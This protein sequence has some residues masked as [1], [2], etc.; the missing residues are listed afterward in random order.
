[1]TQLSQV[2]EHVPFITTIYSVELQ[3]CEKL[4]PAVRAIRAADIDP[5][6]PKSNRGGW[7]SKTFQFHSN[8]EF[9][10]LL[11]AMKPIVS[12][13]YKRIGLNGTAELNNYWFNINKKYNYNV[14]HTHANCKYSGVLYL[15]TPKDCGA[16]VLVRP[17]PLHDHLTFYEGND[18]NTSWFNIDP[19]PNMAVFFPNYIPHFVEQNLTEDEDDERISIAFNFN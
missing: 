15:Q 13:I 3:N 4:I 16:L 17:D 9:M 2:Q 14:Q 1:M 10:P 12:D 11:N 18:L 8:P 6:R 5:T 7:Q 19:K